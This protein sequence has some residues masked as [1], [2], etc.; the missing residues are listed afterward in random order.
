MVA[1]R[2]SAVLSGPFCPEPE[3]RLNRHAPRKITRVLVVDDHPIARA[4][5]IYLLNCH[6]WLTVIGY[7]SDGE[8][9]LLKARDLSPDL[10]LVDIMLPKLSGLALTKALRV[11]LPQTRVIILSL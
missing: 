7:A 5:V 9:G 8:E 1:N 2:S 10:V 3:R 11:E 4:G 6:D